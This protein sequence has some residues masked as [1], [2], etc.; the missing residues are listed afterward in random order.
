V[1]EQSETIE[2]IELPDT[3]RERYLRYA[4]SVITSRALP[5]VRDGLKP[6]QRRILFTMESD[7]GLRPDA[8]TVKSSKVAGL[9]LA[10]YH[11]H[12]DQAIYDAM[13]RMAQPFSL[14]YPLVF[15]QGNF[16]AIT[17]DNAASIRYTE[18]R[19][20]P[21]GHSL[22]TTLGEG[23]VTMRPSYDGTGQEPEVLPTPVPLLLL[24][25]STGIAVGMATNIPPHNLKEV[26]KAT[27]ALIAD[28]ELTVAQLLRS[29]RGPDFPTGG[30]VLASKAEL[31]QI[32]ETGRGTFKLRGTWT[33]EETQAERQRVPR[34]SLVITS[35]PYGTTTAQIIGKIRDLLEAKKLPAVGQVSDQTSA[36]DG[37]RVVLE[38][39][40]EADAQVIAAALCKLTPLEVTFGVNLTC[41]FPTAGAAGRPDQVDLKTILRGWL[42]FRFDV[43]TRSLTYKSEQE[44]K[45][46]HLLHGF[47]IILAKVTEA[48]EIVRKAKD[49]ADASEKLQKRF[50]LD[51]L[52]A[53]AVLERRIYQL[54]SLEIQKVKDELAERTAEKA[55]LDKLLASD[56]A[57][58]SLIARELEQLGE[59]FGDARRTR[60]VGESDDE[61]AF[62][63]TALVKKEDTHVVVS[64]QGRLKRV[65]ALGDPSKIRLRDPDGLLGVV[66]GSTLAHLALFSNLGSIYVMALH[67]VPQTAGFGEPVQKFFNFADGER[68]VAAVSLD[69]RITPPAGQEV[70]LVVV[71]SAGNVSRIPLDAHREPT[72]RAGR[73]LVKLDEGTEV[74]AVEAATPGATLLL[75]TSK[76]NGLRTKADDAPA[77]ASAGKGKRGIELGKGETVVAATTKDSLLLETRR[78]AT[79]T[80]TA[81]ELGKKLGEFG[82]PGVSVKREGW[83]RALPPPPELIAFEGAEPGASGAQERPD[84]RDEGAGE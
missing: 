15:G 70:H 72:T 36:D 26:V 6:V 37:V 34:R 18:A 23:T 73:R 35:I 66:Q 11:P 81:K 17:G 5:D 16:G 4:M 10:N 12:G 7:L 60:L 49:K 55:R 82:G 48:I 80:V 61:V 21:L 19:L 43:V 3:A 38:L 22:M 33:V 47:T 65:R 20:L 74:V 24:N 2:A 62:D 67:D 63:P 56:K 40:S 51:E 39:K 83:T 53:D 30:E 68:I 31:K 58:W 41:L 52:Q 59:Q 44:G 9:V 64:T 32:Y 46:I 75:V 27:V 79:E 76:G 77:L 84:T 1:S 57:R 8:R 71:T 69:P 25:G 29:L 13:V 78:G 50:K 45:R 28:P 54:A 42:D 14:R